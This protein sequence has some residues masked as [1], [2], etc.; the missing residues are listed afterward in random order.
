MK[1]NIFNLQVASR[2]IKL[3]KVVSTIPV[4]QYLLNV[5]QVNR[6]KLKDKS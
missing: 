3:A 6:H 2:N 5:N 1:L 4:H